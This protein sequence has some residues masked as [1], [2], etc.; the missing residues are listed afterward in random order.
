[1]EWQTSAI[2]GATCTENSGFRNG[3]DSA[4][5]ADARSTVILRQRC[6]LFVFPLHPYLPIRFRWRRHWCSRRWCILSWRCGERGWS[7]RAAYPVPSVRRVRGGRQTVLRQRLQLSRDG[8]RALSVSI[9]ISSRCLR[10]RRLLRPSSVRL[11]VFLLPR[12]PLSGFEKPVRFHGLPRCW[13]LCW[14]P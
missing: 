11:Y 14:R 8:S 7:R 3:K 13:P 1:M 4:T 2:P 6:A 12:S 5:G 9:R 10:L